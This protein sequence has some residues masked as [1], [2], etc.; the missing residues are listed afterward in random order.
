MKK[1]T[2]CT[3]YGTFNCEAD[4][5]EFTEELNG[6]PEGHAIKFSLKKQLVAIFKQW[7]ILVIVLENTP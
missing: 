6:Y 2:I 7:D 1:Y 5:I 3:K 4:E